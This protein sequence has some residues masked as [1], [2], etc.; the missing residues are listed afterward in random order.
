[1]SAF[2]R[3]SAAELQLDDMFGLKYNQDESGLDDEED[4]PMGVRTQFIGASSQGGQS[5]IS[6]KFVFDN[7]LGVS[8]GNV[9]DVIHG[10]FNPDSF[11]KV[12][13]QVAIQNEGIEFPDTDFTVIVPQQEPVEID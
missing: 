13:P 12:F 2:Y 8:Q 10:K 5:H 3:R 4:E 1:M 6:I 11:N 9:N 7:P